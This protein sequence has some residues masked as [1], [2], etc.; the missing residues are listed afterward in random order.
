[1]AF[2]IENVFKYHKPLPDQGLRYE[3]IRAAARDFARLLEKSCP[4]SRE[5]SIALTKLQETVMF[6]NAAIAIN[7]KEAV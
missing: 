6:A 2:D 5:K 4:E 7:E 3:A 1:M